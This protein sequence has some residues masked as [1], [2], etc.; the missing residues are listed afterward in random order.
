MAFLSCTPQ[1]LGDADSITPEHRYSARSP[2]V[3]QT[4]SRSSGPLFGSEAAEYLEYSQ[5]GK[6]AGIAASILILR[7]YLLLPL[8]HT[9]DVSKF[10]L[11]IYRP[12][13]K[14]GCSER[15]LPA[16]KSTNIPIVFF[17]DRD[18]RTE[19]LPSSN[20]EALFQE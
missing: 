5:E 17:T 19:F 9:E 10:L 12:L 2:Q 8:C 13:W 18:I 6:L 16:M 3:A 1:L 11:I 15:A 7:K 4:S 14:A 20:P